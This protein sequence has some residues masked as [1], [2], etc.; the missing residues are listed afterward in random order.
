MYLEHGY[1]VLKG[2]IGPGKHDLSVHTF[3]ASKSDA[4]HSFFALVRSQ[5]IF[6][7]ETWRDSEKYICT[8]TTV[9][10]YFN[11]STCSL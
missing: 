6:Q 3:A 9:Q 8:L 1:Y 4:L 10:L 2:D 7:V 5:Q 11:N